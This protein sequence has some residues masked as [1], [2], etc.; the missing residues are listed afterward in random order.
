[1]Y[2][3]TQLSSRGWEI[4]VLIARKGPITLAGLAAATGL[5]KTSLRQQVDRLASAGWVERSR[6]HGKPGRPVDVFSI[7]DQSRQLF[8]RQTDEFARTL[9]EEITDTEGESKLREVVAGVGR[10]LAR[11]LGPL[12][13]E[14]PLTER[15]ERLAESF[16]EAGALNDVAPS[17]RGLTLTIHT[18]PYHGLASGRHVICE[19]ERELVSRLVGA[20]TRLSHCMADGHS[21]CE[22][23][24]VG[25]P[26]Q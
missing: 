11:R 20:E 5:A 15:V 19:M 26:Q 22:L 6:R 23:D 25:E 18:C 8:T 4:I 12:V 21:R 17:E 3:N 10:R 24:V 2:R 9:V 7:S 16:C 13:G 14:G 1:M